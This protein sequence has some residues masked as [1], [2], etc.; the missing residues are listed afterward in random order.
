MA[1]LQINIKSYYGFPQMNY[2]QWKMHQQILRSEVNRALEITWARCTFIH[3]REVKQ[4]AKV[5][6]ACW[7]HLLP[8][9]STS[10]LEASIELSGELKHLGSGHLRAREDTRITSKRKKVG[11]LTPPRE[12]VI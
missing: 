1:A 2:H 11:V 8:S 12:E 5:H 10:S 3:L 6:T 4:C 7:W 9:P